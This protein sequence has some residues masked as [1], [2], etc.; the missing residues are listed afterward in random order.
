MS[1]TKVLHKGEPVKNRRIAAA[2]ISAVSLLSLAACSG[3]SSADTHDGGGS[4]AVLTVA[5]SAVGHHLG[6]GRVLLDRGHVHGQPLRAA[7]LEEPVRQRR[8]R[9]RPPSRR[10][11]TSSADGLTLDVHHPSGR[12]LPRPA[13][14]STPLRSRRASTL[15]RTTAAPPSSGPRSRRSRLH[16]PDDSTVVFKLTYAAPGRPDRRRRRTVRGSWRPSALEAVAKDEKYFES[17]I[18][19][20][21]G[22]YTAR[23]RTR[24]GTKVVLK[25]YDDYWN[26]DEAGDLRHRRRGDHFRRCHRAA[27]A[28]L[29]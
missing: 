28:D 12:H 1:F 22:P 4:T 15:P 25:K 29:R 26:A 17:G 10:A 2:L 11:G 14:R 7:A 16:A 3:G 24:P 13:R 5:S 20:G 27:D 21:T 8:G 23:T 6:P 18:D 19:A 9:T